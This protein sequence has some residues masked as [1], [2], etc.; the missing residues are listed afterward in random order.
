MGQP[1]PAWGTG[2]T[3]SRWV[4]GP[5]LAQQ[6]EGN[7]LSGSCQETHLLLVGL[8]LV[9]LFLVGNLHTEP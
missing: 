6:W 3:G 9:G 5:V 4:H 7:P 1:R 8:F 2:E